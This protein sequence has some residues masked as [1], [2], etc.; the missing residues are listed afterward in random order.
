MLRAKYFLKGISNKN[1]LGGNIPPLSSTIR[2]TI[3]DGHCF[4]SED[5]IV[6]DVLFWTPNHGT[7]KQ[8]RQSK[9]LLIAKKL[10]IEK[11]KYVV[12]ISSYLVAFEFTK[13]L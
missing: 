7:T 6:K 4:R 3:F 10:M 12:E 2:R 5:E 1:R 8:A 11:V 13:I 9:K